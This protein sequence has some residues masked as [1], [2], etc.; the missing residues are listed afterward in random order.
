MSPRDS[1]PGPMKSKKL[2][3]EKA[4]VSAVSKYFEKAP[5]RLKATT[6]DTESLIINAFHRYFV[7][8]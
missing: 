5:C 2:K 1:F 8:K 4:I 7:T 6:D 3:G